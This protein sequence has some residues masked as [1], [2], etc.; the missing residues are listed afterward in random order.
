VA[1]S[2]DLIKENKLLNTPG[3]FNSLKKK[4]K[5]KKKIII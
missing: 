3:E 4:K 2:N 1:T 5:K